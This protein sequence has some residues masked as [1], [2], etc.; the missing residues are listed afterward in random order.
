M[1]R[2]STLLLLQH[3]VSSAFA[4]RHFGQ[5]QI[6]AY[7]Y[8]KLLIINS[9]AGFRSNMVA[10]APL[11]TCKREETSTLATR[12]AE[13][14]DASRC[15]ADADSCITALKKYKD[16]VSAGGGHT[17]GLPALRQ[18][19]LRVSIQSE[20]GSSLHRSTSYG[21]ARAAPILQCEHS[22][23]FASCNGENR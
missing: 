4:A 8:M 11:Q 23:R 19:S 6:K 3:R 17:R 14:L 1:V 10:G 5:L 18:P 12:C 9:L 21:R 22:S 20:S 16:A 7:N 15:A 2:N 13:V